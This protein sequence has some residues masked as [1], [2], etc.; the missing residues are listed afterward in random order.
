MTSISE[1]STATALP[2]KA[3]A[4]DCKLTASRISSEQRGPRVKHSSPDR[5]VRRRFCCRLLLKGNRMELGSTILTPVSDTTPV[6]LQYKFYWVHERLW[7][8]SWID[9]YHA[10]APGLARE[11]QS[12][13]GAS[14]Q[15][16]CDDFAFEILIEF[17]SK[18]KLPLKIKTESRTFKNVEEVFDVE[19]G[20]PPTPTGFALDVAFRAGAKDVVRNSLP[21]ALSDLKPGDIFAEFN[22]QHIQVV[23]SV[24]PTRIEIM[25]GNFPGVLT[26]VRKQQSWLDFGFIF[27]NK[28]LNARESPNYLGVPVQNAVYELRN[29]AWLYQRMYGDDRAWDS[30]PW[31]DMNRHMR[32]D[33]FEFNRL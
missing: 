21:V 11:I 4:I 15:F 32:W 20:N 29:G 18:N 16:S 8:Q 17:A 6:T 24:S 31:N 30:K 28:S 1:L 10:A 5:T 27:R 19:G 26:T 7:D 2:S 9:K 14:G 25:Q 12:R 33:F 22:Q 23:I 3:Y 13:K